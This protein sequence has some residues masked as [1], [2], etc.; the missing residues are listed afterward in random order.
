[1]ERKRKFWGWGYED[2]D[3]EVAH[4][5]AIAAA[6]AQRFAIDPLEI[7]SPPR[8]EEISLRPSRLTVPPRL[9]EITSTTAEDRAA[10]TYGK[11]FRDLVR[12]Y[13]REYPNPPDVVAFPRDEE[14]VV[15]VLE[16][17]DTAR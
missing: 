10:H 17:A 9:A 8:I 15:A 1:M 16:W 14:E 12:A 7:A 11:S 13:R 3:P 5:K 4:Q 6:L 2:G